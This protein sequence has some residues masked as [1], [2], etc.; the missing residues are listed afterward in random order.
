M[1]AFQKQL[2]VGN[3]PGNSAVGQHLSDVTQSNHITCY[4]Q[5][6]SKILYNKLYICH[7]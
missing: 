1:V 2:T 5:N 3:D 7:K 6:S 4:S